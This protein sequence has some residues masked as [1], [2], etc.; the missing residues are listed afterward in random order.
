MQNGGVDEAAGDGE[1]PGLLSL[2]SRGVEEAD[3]HEM[4]DMGQFALRSGSSPQSGLRSRSSRF[5]PGGEYEGGALTQGTGTV[6]ASGGAVGQM[7]GAGRL[8]TANGGEEAK[9]SEEFI[10]NYTMELLEAVGHEQAISPKLVALVTS[11]LAF[12]LPQGWHCISQH[13][14]QVSYATPTGQT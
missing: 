8:E 14:A 11:L 4:A 1:D 5:G 7:E 13:H 6:S 9:Y 10:Q 3:I 12:P 2:G